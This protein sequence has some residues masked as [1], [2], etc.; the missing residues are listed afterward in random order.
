M[1]EKH[2]KDS[3]PGTEVSVNQSVSTEN[4]HSPLAGPCQAVP[5]AQWKHSGSLG[6]LRHLLVP[7]RMRSKSTLALL[8]IFFS[9]LTPAATAKFVLICHTSNHPEA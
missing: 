7:L 3:H 5:A 1:G 9:T 2:E 6:F 8:E 4:M